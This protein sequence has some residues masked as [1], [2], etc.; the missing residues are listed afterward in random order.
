MEKFKGDK[1]VLRPVLEED[2]D[3]FVD[4]MN[5]FEASLYTGSLDGLY[6][7]EDER[8][9]FEKSSDKKQFSILCEERLIGVVE[10][11]D[12]HEVDR[13][14]TLGIMLGDPDYRSKGLGYDIVM[15][16]L[17]YGFYILNLRSIDLTCVDF[18]KR[19]Q[20]LYKAC[21]FKEVGHRRK[22][23]YLLGDYRD[24]LYMDILR[25]D[26]EP[27]RICQEIEKYL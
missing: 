14:A 19:A 21:G 7:K 15:L 17:D 8:A 9:Y 2:L 18:N 25:E 23:R 1:V 11:F 20:A 5:D 16:A 6:R 3:R 12:I 26:H 13:S 10:L 22:A 24:I 4:F 27:Y